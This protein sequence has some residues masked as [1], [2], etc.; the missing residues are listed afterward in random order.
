MVTGLD[1]IKTELKN[2]NQLLP[3]IN[4]KETFLNIFR[5]EVI[6]HSWTMI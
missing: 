3:Q 1:Y 6:V 2:K 5:L 4:E